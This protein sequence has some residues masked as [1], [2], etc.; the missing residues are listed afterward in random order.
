[1]KQALKHGLRLLE[2]HRV[3]ENIQSNWLNPCI[4]KNTVLRKLAKNEFEKD[5]FKLMNHS[6]FGKMIEKL[7]DIKLIVTEQRRKKL[8]SEPN[9]TPCT[10]FSDDLMAAEMRKIRIYMN[11]PIIVGQTILDKSKMLMYEFYYEYLKPK[12]SNKVDLLYM[13][14]DSFILEIKTDDFFEDTKKDLVRWFD[15]SNYHKDMV[16]PDELQCLFNNEIVKCIRYRIKSTPYSVDTVQ[17]NKIALK[18]SDNKRLKSFN[19][20]TTF[21]YGTSAFRVCAEELR[22]KITAN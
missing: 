13:D 14:K 15:T 21:P 20:I 3:I 8:V 2:V 4:D 7:I 12:C 17:I 18:N 11:K 6:V 9:Y 5:F 19:D 1:M 16:L 22:G 10:A